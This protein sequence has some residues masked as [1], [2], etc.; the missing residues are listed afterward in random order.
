MN[1]RQKLHTGDIADQRSA[2]Q[3]AAADEPISR[4]EIDEPVS[5]EPTDERSGV[6]NQSRSSLGEGAPEAE[7]PLLPAAD[8]QRLQRRWEE[9]QSGFVDEPR[10][11][12]EQADAL[13]ADLM[14][15]LAVAF[16]DAR[17]RLEEQWA[18]GEDVS[19]EDLRQALTRY[20]SFFQRL[21][22]A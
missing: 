19:T 5:L 21:L 15:Q 22:T 9:I 14:Q 17:Q 6:D 12:V 18:S 16:A 3:S 8:N 7:A 2:R 20:R 4:D 13:V 10:R 1:E 11:M